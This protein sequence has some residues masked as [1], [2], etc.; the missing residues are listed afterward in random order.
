M[1]LSAVVAACLL[2]CG[3]TADSQ[4]QDRVMMVTWRG[5]EEA[6]RGFQDYLAERNVPAEIIIRD[7]EQDESVLP[8]ILAEAR[9]GKIDLIVTWGT[10]VSTG[11]AG[12]LATIDDDAFNHEI[13]QVF[14]IVADP[15]GAGLIGSLDATG[16]PNLTGTYNRVP[17]QVNI[18]TIR[19]Y[20]PA[21]GHLGLLYNGDEENSV[22]KRDELEALADAMGFRF[23]ALELPTAESGGPRIED[24]PAKLAEL[25]EA[26]VD[27]VY[28]GSSSFLQKHGDA[29]TS[30][31][32][33]AGLPVLSPYESLARKSHA[34]LSVAAS[35]YEVGRLA[36]GQAEKILSDGASP[37]DLPVARMQN[38]AVVINLDAAKRLNMFPPIG[39]LQVA[40]TVN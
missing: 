16:R 5:C 20:Y 12:T 23:T 30:A 2:I 31:A 37:G 11:I 8:S 24:F 7:A 36:G 38:F 32:V 28:L 19:S 17:E 9:A 34:L 15:V 33:D 10:T 35:Y 26:G 1:R 21:F 14:M 6:C 4:A 18:E 3:V 40:E 13:P 22:L 25:K 27:F 39:L 29:F